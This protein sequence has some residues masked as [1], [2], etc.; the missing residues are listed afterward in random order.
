MLL[1]N[2]TAFIHCLLSC[3]Y[4]CISI[5][6]DPDCTVMGYDNMQSCLRS[7]KFRVNPEDGSNMLL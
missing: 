5:H 7:P 6:A 3:K 1:I 2:I 4:V